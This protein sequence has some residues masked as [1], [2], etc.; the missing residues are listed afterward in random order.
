MLLT[1]TCVSGINLQEF[2]PKKLNQLGVYTKRR[3]C[4]LSTLTGRFFNTWDQD[5]D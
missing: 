4:A 1:E 5:A 3:C 2:T